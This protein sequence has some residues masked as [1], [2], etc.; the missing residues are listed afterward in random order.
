MVKIWDRDNQKIFIQVI[1]INMT[2]IKLKIY[3]LKEFKKNS[4]NVIEKISNITKI[5]KSVFKIEFIDKFPRNQSG[6]IL[7]NKLN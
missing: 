3:C 2:W 5:N 6:K 4:S 7:Y 1:K